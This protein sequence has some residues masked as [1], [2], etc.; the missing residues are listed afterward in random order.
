[1]TTYE[2]MAAVS[3]IDTIKKISP[4]AVIV[5]PTDFW[6]KM[7]RYPEI[8]D[9]NEKDQESATELPRKFYNKR[10]IISYR[11]NYIWKHEC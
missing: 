3:I 7:Y 1:M 11:F 9:P 10:C 6:P 5:K 4:Q 2:W 8:S